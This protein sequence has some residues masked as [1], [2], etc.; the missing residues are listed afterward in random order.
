MS[1]MAKNKGLMTEVEAQVFWSVLAY[2]WYL[3]SLR[4]FV[5]F[6]TAAAVLE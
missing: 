1:T 2:T 6:T 4:V 5:T 3:V